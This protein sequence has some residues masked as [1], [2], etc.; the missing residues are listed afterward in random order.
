MDLRNRHHSTNL[1]VSAFTAPAA[2]I[3]VVIATEAV[4][5]PYG[6]LPEF[7]TLTK[8]PDYHQPVLHDVVHRIETQGQLVHSKARRLAS[9]RLIAARNEFQH[10]LNLGIVSP[11][12]SNWSTALHMVPKPNGDWRPCGDYRAL[13][14]RTIPDRYPIPHVQDFTSALKG[15]SVF[16][17]I[18]LVRAYHLI[19]MHEGDRAKT[20]ITT[21]FGLF[22]FSRMPFGLRNAAQTFQRFMD[23]LVRGLPFVLTDI[24]D[25][26]IASPVEAPHRRHLHEVFS[27]LAK[28][29]V[30]INAAKCPFSVSS[31][32][33]LSHHISADGIR[34]MDEG[35][36]YPGLPSAAIRAYSS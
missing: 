24:D 21:P 29:G 9:D 34:R 25:L 33:F 32:T 15:N 12:S 36:G 30:S 27:R 4:T 20:A 11:S 28:Y 14:N 19:P 2:A 17:K 7:P 8:P 35:A 26:L 5:D 22:Q 10:L 31:L 16:S 6:L 18:D 13:N 23:T 1:S 3:D